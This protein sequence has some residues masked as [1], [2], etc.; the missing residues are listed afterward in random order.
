MFLSNSKCFVFFWTPCSVW[1]LHCKWIK[2]LFVSWRESVWFREITIE[3][4]N[5]FIPNSN[6]SY[7]H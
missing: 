1:E 5:Y 6:F 3:T 4:I 2:K 7:R